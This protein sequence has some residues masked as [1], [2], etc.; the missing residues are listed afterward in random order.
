[1]PASSATARS[2]CGARRV[3]DPTRLKTAERI[4]SAEPNDGLPA[5]VTYQPCAIV[6]SSLGPVEKPLPVV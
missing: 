2:S 5:A 3:D 1:M 6:D 4:V